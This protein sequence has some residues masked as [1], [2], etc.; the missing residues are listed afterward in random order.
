MK[1]LKR[2]LLFV[3]FVILYISLLVAVS[4][5]F[6]LLNSSFWIETFRR[7]KVYENF[8]KSLTSSFK[9]EYGEVSETILDSMLDS[10]LNKDMIQDYTE[11]NIVNVLNFMDGR[12]ELKI[13]IPVNKFPK[14]TLSPRLAVKEEYTLSDLQKSFG[15]MVPAQNITYLSQVGTIATISLIISFIFFALGLWG[16]YKTVDPGSKLIFPGLTIII[17]S[18]LVF[19]II[20]LANIESRNIVKDLLTGE[21]IQVLI[22]TVGPPAVRAIMNLWTY[23]NLVVLICGVILLFLKKP[24]KVSS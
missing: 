6:Q 15:V 14:G 1:V 8:E 9:R 16:L 21:P 7:E 10:F 19:I 5:R 20:L 24:V 11:K 22:G 3:N 2:T 4:F 23:I 13:Y 17:S 12:D 18:I